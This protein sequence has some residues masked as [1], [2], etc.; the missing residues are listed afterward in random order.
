MCVKDAT[1]VA[2]MPVQGAVQVALVTVNRTVP[3]DVQLVVLRIAQPHVPGLAPAH[4]NLP[5][6]LIVKTA[7]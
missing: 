2:P 7:V 5:A 3:G 1:S 6:R 4:V